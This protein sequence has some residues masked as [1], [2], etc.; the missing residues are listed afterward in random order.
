MDQGV[1]TSVPGAVEQSSQ[2]IADMASDYNE[3]APGAKM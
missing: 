2:S 1:T 3:C